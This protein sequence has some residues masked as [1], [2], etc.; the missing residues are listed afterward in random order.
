MPDWQPSASIAAMQQRAELL[1]RI[2]KFFARRSVLEVETPLMS[3]HAVSDPHI[4]SIATRYQPAGGQTQSLYLQT[5]P[6]YAMKR[7]LAAGSGPIYQICK[8]FRNGE[9][10]RRHNPEF[11]M[12]EW[13]RPGFTD[14][15]LMD[16]VEALLAPLLGFFRVERFTYVDV[17]QQHLGIDPTELTATELK[18]ITCQHVD[19]QLDDDD[20]ATWMDLL[21]SHIIE[22]RLAHFPAV[23]IYEYPAAQAALARVR[24]GRQGKP[25]AAR[26]ELFVQGVELANGYH[27]LTDP[28]EQK[29]RFQ[30]D[31]QYRAQRDLPQRPLDINLVQALEAGL[32][33]CAGVALGLDRLLML[34][35]EADELSEVLSFD[36]NRA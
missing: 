2:R 5:S 21:F 8:A 3:H 30:A 9:F 1:S 18:Q 20:P 19:I 10:G 32:P 4:D 22:P 24:P 7:L 36:F 25:V 14:M 11:T 31:Q 16:E 13:Y 34:L 28:A 33:D 26:F 15:D 6:E 27:E 12:L 35:M 29:R 17:F 23:F